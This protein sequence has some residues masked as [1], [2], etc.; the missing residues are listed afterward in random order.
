MLACAD[1]VKRE[2]YI[3]RRVGAEGWQRWGV[4]WGGME[5]TNAFRIRI[6]VGENKE[7]VKA[8]RKGKITISNSM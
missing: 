6:S 5:G 3:G 8:K 2:G 4:G 7:Q 1:E